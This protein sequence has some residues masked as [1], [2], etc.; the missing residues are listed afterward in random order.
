MNPGDQL[1]TS[2]L[3]AIGIKNLR[4][5][6]N[7]PDLEL[8]PITVFV[9]ANSSGKST[10]LRT[11]PL[12]RQ[13]VEARKASPL[14]WFGRFVDFGSF[15]EAVFHN[16]EKLPIELRFKLQTVI[17]DDDD[18]DIFTYVEGI[19]SSSNAKSPETI[20]VAV[21]ISGTEEEFRGFV[22]EVSVGVRNDNFRFNI[23]RGGAVTNIFYNGTSIADRFSGLVV[24]RESSLIPRIGTYAERS[25]STLEGATAEK[26][27]VFTSSD[28]GTARIVQKLRPYFSKKAKEQTLWLFARRLQYGSIDEILAQ[29]IKI[30]PTHKIL[31]K[32]IKSLSGN[33]EL[34]SDVR[35]SIMMN[36]LPR[37]LSASELRVEGFAKRISYIAP[38]RASTE[39]YYR[40]QD[41]AVD[42]V[43]PE[44]E[45]IPMFLQTLSLQDRMGL[46][47]W[48][49]KHFNFSVEA[50]Y[51]SGHV[52]LRYKDPHQQRYY[53]LADMGF[54][55]SQLLP[56][57]VQIWSQTNLTGNKQRLR[58][59]RSA[60]RSRLFAI[61][62]PE[63]HLH[64]NLQARFADLLAAVVNRSEPSTTTTR[65]VIETHSEAIINRL[66]ALVRE[67]KLTA[68][69]V[70][71]V[72]FERDDETAETA[73]RIAHYNSHGQLENW[74]F[75][76][77][78][79]E[80]S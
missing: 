30:A 32:R 58:S 45:N 75:G 11:F 65:F 37:W 5:L 34:V 22:S 1:G 16:D 26:V 20:S 68:S 38:V 70:S 66:G 49:N 9:G 53:N 76:F 31:Q 44:G 43:D 29:I 36:Y 54:G 63:L 12:L 57:L 18:D 52:S 79:A 27:K 51:S 59:Q 10:F 21:S 8:R 6:R 33:A 80:Q 55:F 46:S 50:E 64:P 39:R 77:F 7:T 69:D 13:S 61:E 19:G 23:E 42:E 40:A 72:V 62:Q 2:S 71:V 74:P 67:G 73:L 35:L 14:L 17:S 78:A 24:A 4:S 56:I 15:R 3:N 48:L 47:Q 60:G 25:I 41:L 28:L